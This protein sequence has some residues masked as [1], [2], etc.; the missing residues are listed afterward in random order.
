MIRASVVLPL[1]G[2]PCRI[3]EWRRPSSIARRSAE[4]G[5]SSRCLPDELLERVRAASASRAARPAA[6]ARAFAAEL[7]VAEQS[8]HGGSMGRATLTSARSSAADDRQRGV[9]QRPVGRDRVAAGGGR[10]AAEIGEAAAR[11]LDDHLRRGEIPQRDDRLA[12]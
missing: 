3:I 1:P 6:A 11:L 9:V 12:A 7:V 10:D 8:L 5:A 4:P 2:G